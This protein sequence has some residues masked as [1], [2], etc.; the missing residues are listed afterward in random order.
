MTE[1]VV[2][3]VKKH[4]ENTFD[5]GGVGKNNE[6]EEERQKERVVRE[7]SNHSIF[8]GPH[9]GGESKNAME[10]YAREAK[11][12]PLTNVNH[13]SE[14][15]PKLF[16]GENVAIVFSEEDAPLGASPSQ[17]CISSKCKDRG[18]EHPSGIRTTTEAQ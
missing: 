4:K 7:G 5:R 1:W 13:L 11:E 10:K 16:K 3:E 2:R 12:R 18:K 8:G 15:P 17:R 14:R 6:K 9:V